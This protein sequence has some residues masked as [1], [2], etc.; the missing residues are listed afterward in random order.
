MIE[1]EIARGPYT[2]TETSR[3]PPGKYTW[4][5]LLHQTAGTQNR[6]IAHPEA[7]N[8]PACCKCLLIRAQTASG[9][10]LGFETGL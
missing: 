7:K 5:L 8:Q 6:G 4:R 1:R 10:R 3:G 2:G 9:H